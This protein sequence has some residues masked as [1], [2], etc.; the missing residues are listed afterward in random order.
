MN[1]MKDILKNTRLAGKSEQYVPVALR[2]AADSLRSEA[3]AIRN[4]GLMLFRAVIDRLLGTNDAYVEDEVATKRRVDFEHHQDLLELVIGLLST[5]PTSMNSGEGARNEGVFP[6]LQLLQRL[7]LQRLHRNHSPKSTL[8]M[9]S[10]RPPRSTRRPTSTAS[11]TSAMPHHQP[12]RTAS[13]LPN[14]QL[15]TV[16]P[17]K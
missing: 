1:C 12:E 13:E 15:R 4:C 2:L 7:P 17:S 16:L 14:R 6:A 9:R 5:A 11:R 3:W 8:D 10:T